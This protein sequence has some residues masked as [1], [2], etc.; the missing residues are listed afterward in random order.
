M[1]IF[2]K[3]KD[4]IKSEFSDQIA[5]ISEQHVKLSVK[6]DIAKR[7]IKNRK[8]I[9]FYFDYFMCNYIQ[10]LEYL[11]DDFHISYIDSSE[12]IEDE[13]NIDVNEEIDIL[14]STYNRLLKHKF[15]G[16][17]YS[18]KINLLPTKTL[19]T[20]WKIINDILKE[21]PK[22]LRYFKSVCGCDVYKNI[23]IKKEF[24][25]LADAHYLKE[26]FNYIV[27]VSEG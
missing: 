13:E 16:N 20:K 17:K 27:K 23:D 5:F 21:Y 24:R 9:Y 7:A 26:D 3:L 10:I 14:K 11:K 25:L 15:L 12:I 22:L 4:K 2:A 8:D 18:I 19:I 6:R 1:Q